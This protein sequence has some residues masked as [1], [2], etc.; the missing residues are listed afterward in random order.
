MWTQKQ[1]EKYAARA[2]RENRKLNWVWNGMHRRINDPKR[3]NHESYKGKTVCPE[4]CGPEGLQRFKVWARANGWKP[5]LQIDRRDNNGNYTPDNCRFV[6]RSEN[7]RNRT[8]NRTLTING[9]TRIMTEWSE[10]PGAAKPHI[11]WKRL[12]RGWD[13]ERAVFGERMDLRFLTIAGR[14]KSL[15]QWAQNVGATTC[16]SNIYHNIK[17]RL[18]R[19]WPPD[20]AVFGR[21]PKIEFNPCAEFA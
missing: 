7:M 4:W 5:G 19:G 18:L 15:L 13:D 20:E 3:H 8:D 6:T 16:R 2:D 21:V 12:N 14:T 9:V 11:I 17:K 10:Q 1:R